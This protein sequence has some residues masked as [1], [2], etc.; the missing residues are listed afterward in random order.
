MKKMR[1]KAS[2]GEREISVRIRKTKLIRNWNEN[3]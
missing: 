2:E 1:E 3:V